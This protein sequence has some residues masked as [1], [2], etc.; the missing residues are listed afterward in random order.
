M[1]MLKERLNT[2]LKAK[3]NSTLYL[4]NYKIKWE[5]WVC[6]LLIW[7]QYIKQFL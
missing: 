5:V 3:G 7:R 2:Y 6:I 1:K 4:Y